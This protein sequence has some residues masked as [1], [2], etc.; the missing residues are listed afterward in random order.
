M[1]DAVAPARRRWLAFCCR[2]ALGLALLAVAGAAAAQPLAAN[3]GDGASAAQHPAGERGLLWRIS[4]GSAEPS[5]L[6]GTIHL[7]DPRVTELPSA[8]RDRLERCALFV[9]EAIPDPSAF[10]E[11]SGEMFL[12][13]EHTLESLVGPSLFGQVAGMLEQQGLPPQM[14]QLLQPWA[15][16]LLLSTPRPKTGM[17]LDRVLY[18]EAGRQNKTMHPLETL[19]EQV[20]LFADLPESD[21]IRLLRLA[22]KQFDRLPGH[23]EELTQA[24]LQGDL[25]TLEVLARRQ[26]GDDAELA[27]R[28]DRRIVSERNVRMVSRLLPLLDRGSAFVA[29]GALHL[30][31]SDGMLNLLRNAGVAVEPVR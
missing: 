16:T 12:R 24:Y 11:M 3:A 8:V 18:L 29:V 5:F 10:L 20:S 31:G 2:Q 4:R 27:G 9:P 1:C 15:A 13:G 22:V 21:Q 25:A 7:E 26:M 17:F 28:I 23:V 30:P 19:A 6:F 14:T